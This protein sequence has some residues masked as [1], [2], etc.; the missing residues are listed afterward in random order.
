MDD[1]Q[2]NNAGDQNAV[3]SAILFRTNPVW[4]FVNVNAIGNGTNFQESNDLI[5][6]NLTY[7][8]FDPI[9]LQETKG[10]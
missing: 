5:I 3:M 2:L 10:W 4:T 6:N 9:I 7:A 1:F 8:D